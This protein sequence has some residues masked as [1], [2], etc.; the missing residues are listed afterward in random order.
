MRRKSVALRA[1]AGAS[2]VLRRQKTEVIVL[3]DSQEET[4]GTESDVQLLDSSYSN[5]PSSPQHS[6]ADVTHEEK[7]FKS[8]EAV[9]ASAVS[10]DTS[11]SSAL[12]P[13]SM[14]TSLDL[15]TADESGAA[16]SQL[17]LNSSSLSQS[18]GTP[19]LEGGTPSSSGKLLPAAAK[20]ADG[21]T[22]HLPFENLPNATG[23][24]AKVRKII[25][26]T[27]DSWDD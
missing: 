12:Q 10:L 4:D 5:A 19:I 22:E 3:D 1:L 17:Q 11:T 13:A 16:S 8:P 27:K 15:D 9:S 24:F 23:Q 26:Q 7:V 25:K 18:S 20:F 14:N 21:I 6:A 2:P